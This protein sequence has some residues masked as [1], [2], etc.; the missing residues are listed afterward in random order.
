M[1]SERFCLWMR[2]NG[3]KFGWDQKVEFKKSFKFYCQILLKFLSTVDLLVKIL[4]EGVNC[5]ESS[6]SVRVP[7][8]AYCRKKLFFFWNIF[9]FVFESI[10][11]TL[12]LSSSTNGIKISFVIT[13]PI[14]YFI[15]HLFKLFCWNVMYCDICIYVLHFT[16]VNCIKNF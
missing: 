10:C 15:W 7:W 2:Q 8:F 11:Q 6:P 3:T 12:F 4:D 13:M 5:S 1:R 14:F 16:V 9:L